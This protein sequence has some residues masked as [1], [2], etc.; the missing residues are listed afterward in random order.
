[1]FSN[2]N[3]I[4]FETLLDWFAKGQAEDSWFVEKKPSKLRELHSMQI[5]FCPCE[6]HNMYDADPLPT[7]L[8]TIIG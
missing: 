7:D 4:E 3:M 5:H 6:L 2:A 8:T 1:M